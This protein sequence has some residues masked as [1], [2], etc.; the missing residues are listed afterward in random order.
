[1]ALA[2][3]PEDLDV[4]LA[5]LDS[6]STAS[7]AVS[8]AGDNQAEPQSIIEDHVRVVTYNLF[9]QRAATYGQD[10][11][12]HL[13]SFP[14]QF[15]HFYHWQEPHPYLQPPQQSYSAPANI[16]ANL[17]SAGPFPQQYFQQQST[18]CSGLVP[19]YTGADSD[20]WLWVTGHLTVGRGGGG[21]M[22]KGWA[23]GQCY[24]WPMGEP[25]D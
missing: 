22:A 3:D 23:E 11:P 6:G 16:V 1:M 7:D 4:F 24:P 25:R 13:P 19:W 9:Q 2:Q 20:N 15:Q 12:G 5:R 14:L 8:N 18:L 17:P 10:L 21:T